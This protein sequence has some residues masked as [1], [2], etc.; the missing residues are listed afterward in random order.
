M[1]V[2]HS[3]FGALFAQCCRL[4]G[5]PLTPYAGDNALVDVALR[6]DPTGGVEWRRHYQFSWRRWALVS[7]TKRLNDDGVLEEH[8]GR[9][10]S[11]QLKVFEQDG[12][13][14]FVSEDYLWRLGRLRIR[15]PALLTPGVTHVIHEQISGQRFR[16]VLKVTHPWLGE[17]FYQEGEF[18]PAPTRTS[19]PRFFYLPMAF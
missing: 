16:F 11:M 2:R 3:F 18:V 19:K 14:H 13:L 12:N 6:V 15:L 1:T 4:I 9:G 17:T 8:V 5:T 7:S 10:F